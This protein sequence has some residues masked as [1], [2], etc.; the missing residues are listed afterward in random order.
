MGKYLSDL[1][2]VSVSYCS[3]LSGFLRPHIAIAKCLS[4]FAQYILTRTWY[5]LIIQIS[6]VLRPEPLLSPSWPEVIAVDIIFLGC[7]MRVRN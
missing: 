7:G 5:P 1:L 4:P 3:V 2:S 6:S